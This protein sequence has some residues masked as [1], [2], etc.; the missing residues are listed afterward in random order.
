MHV[1]ARARVRACVCVSVWRDILNCSCKCL[2]N[3]YRCIYPKPRLLFPFNIN[4]NNY[5]VVDINECLSSPC[6]NG[7]T[8]STPQL[9]MFSCK[10]AAGYTGTNCDSGK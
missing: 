5:Y 2:S 9:N 8:C 10:C 1:C 3:S 4:V 6:E 7:G